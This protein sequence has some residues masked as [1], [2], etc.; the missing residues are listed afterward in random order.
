M[1]SAAH[2]ASGMAAIWAEGR[3][4][5]GAGSC[6]PG[7]RSFQGGGYA[8]AARRTLDISAALVG[9]VVL[10]PLITIVAVAISLEGEGRAFFVQTR[11][12]RHG[13]HFK[14]LKFR[15][16]AGRDA[17]S[18]AHPDHRVTRVGHFLRCTKIDE[19]PQLWNILIGDMSLVGPRPVKPEMAQMLEEQVPGHRHRL[20]VRPGMTGLAQISMERPESV[21]ACARRLAFDLAYIEHRS[22]WLDLRIIWRTIMRPRRSEL[23]EWGSMKGLRPTPCA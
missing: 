14:M 4:A 16:M 9:L 10:L 20:T 11:V 6:S 2:P 5:A 15:T 12:G 3:T 19:I 13:R 8:A 21:E 23:L 7:S 22:L 17:T 18:L 1:E